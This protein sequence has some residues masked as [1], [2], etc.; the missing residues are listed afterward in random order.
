[1]SE[2]MAKKIEEMDFYDLLNLSLDASRQEVERAYLQ[3]VATYHEHALASY[4]VLSPQERNLILDKIEAAFETLADPQR[5]RAYDSTILPSR[6]EYQQKAYFRQSTVRLEIEDASK[7]EKFR[8]KVKSLFFFRKH[9]DSRT[10]E[11]GFELEANGR[12]YGEYLKL[13]RKNRGLSRE[14]IATACNLSVALL[15]ALEE[16]NYSALPRG[17]DPASL[18]RLYARLLG[19]NPENGRGTNQD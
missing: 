11:D 6:P 10:K 8:D 14:Q 18:L 9:R 4:N 1:L 2:I 16:E 5:R 7:E 17:K 3:A 15:E 19:L 13:V 12:Y